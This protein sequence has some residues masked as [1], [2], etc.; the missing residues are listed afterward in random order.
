MKNKNDFNY[1]CGTCQKLHRSSRR[2]LIRV[3]GPARF[4]GGGSVCI[5]SS[6]DRTAKK[7]GFK[8]DRSLENFLYGKG[9][10]TVTMETFRLD[11]K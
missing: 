10:R 3:W 5:C 11:R 8:T 2:H 9:L 7:H 6:C 4:G 1:R